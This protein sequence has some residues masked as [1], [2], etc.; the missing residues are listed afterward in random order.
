MLSSGR[1]YVTVRV[2]KEGFHRCTPDSAVRTLFIPPCQNRH[3]YQL[4]WFLTSDSFQNQ[5]RNNKSL[6]LAG[7]NQN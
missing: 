1:V 7:I 5:K 3:H 2:S 4:W 6:V